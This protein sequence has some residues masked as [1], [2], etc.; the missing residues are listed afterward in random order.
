MNENNSVNK[1]VKVHTEDQSRIRHPA[2]SLI[3]AVAILSTAFIFWVMN[4]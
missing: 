1:D 2:E 3:A 4:R